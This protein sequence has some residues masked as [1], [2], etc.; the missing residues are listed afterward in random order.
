MSDFFQGCSV[1]ERERVCV[2]E[3]DKDGL[4]ESSRRNVTD[5]SLSVISNKAL[6][7]LSAGRHVGNGSR[8]ILHTSQE[9]TVS[10]EKTVSLVPCVNS[11]TACKNKRVLLRK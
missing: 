5:L 6:N 8:K 7:T 10:S 9:G 2:R 1:Y 4:E 11:Y 3:R